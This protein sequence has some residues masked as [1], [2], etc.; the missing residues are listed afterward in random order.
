MAYEVGLGESVVEG[1]GKEKE[2]VG[3]ERERDGERRERSNREYKCS[4]QA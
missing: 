4:F 3:R 2:T 1:K